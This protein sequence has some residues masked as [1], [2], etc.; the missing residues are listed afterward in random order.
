MRIE[1][2][3]RWRAQEESPILWG[4]DQDIENRVWALMSLFD[5]FQVLTRFPV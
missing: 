5:Q 4:S 3:V 2:R 1:E